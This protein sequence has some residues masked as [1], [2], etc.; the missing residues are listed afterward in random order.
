MNLS[1][2]TSTQPLLVDVTRLLDRALQGRK[3]T[4]VDRVGLAYLEHF[5]DRAQALVRFAGRWVV[6]GKS[7]SRA[8]FAA[9]PDPDDGFA[10]RMRWLAGKNYAL[11]WRRPDAGSVLLNTGHSG[12]DS[13]EYA[14]RTRLYGLLPLYFLHDLIPVSH[15]EYGRPGEAEKHRRR[16][17][18]MLT[19][20]RGVIVNSS[21]T[22]QELDAYAS[23][24]G[25]SVPPWVVAHLAPARFPPPS[26]ERPMHEPYFVVLGTI[27][28]RKN[29]LLLLNIWRQMVLELGERAPRLVIIG[30]RGWECEQVLDMLDRCET[31]K[32]AVIELA[33]CDDAA[34]VTW[35][36]HAQALLFPSFVEG[37]G[38]PLVESL[39]VGTPVIA[40]DLPVF[41]ELAG[42]IPVYLDPLDSPG[43]KRL[44]LDYASPDS[45]L[46]QAQFSRM[47]DWK[48]PV[49]ED[50]FRQVEA[51]M[52]SCVTHLGNGEDGGKRC[53]A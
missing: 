31:L 34:L 3:P 18:T 51:L 22:G 48:A 41:R 8:L 40:S 37:Y 16:L 52:G 26:L 29:H 30:Q 20:A 43:W 10:R 50:H 23:N 36:H 46:R 13:V 6:I 4:G 17:R 39:S 19:T 47:S 7:D 33:S 28:A 44:I 42:T 15:P 49:W 21:A 11:N 35:L 5:R 2:Q 24:Q 32:T 45:P 14:K 38:I 53:P 27:E 25:L 9:L 12:L 1:N